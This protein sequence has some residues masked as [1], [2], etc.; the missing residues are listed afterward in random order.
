MAGGNGK[1]G[2]WA[3]VERMFS[4]IGARFK[5]NV[6]A[7][8]KK[9]GVLLKTLVIQRFEQQGPGWA[10]HKPAYAKRKAMRGREQILIDTGQLMGSISS[11]YV[12]YNEGF[13]GVQKGATS[14]GGQDMVNLAAVHEMGSPSRNIPARPFLAPAAKEGEA[15]MTRNYEEAVEKTFKA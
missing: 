9:N 5:A 14:K 2:D 11:V 12:A 4:G 10:A 1:T 6:E 8:T 15:P 7:A 13:V 3:K